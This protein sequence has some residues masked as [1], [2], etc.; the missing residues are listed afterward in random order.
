MGYLSIISSILSIP[1]LELRT[2]PLNPS[3][4]VSSQTSDSVDIPVIGTVFNP[5]LTYYTNV[6]LDTLALSLTPTSSTPAPPSAT[7]ASSAEQSSIAL[8]KRPAKN[9]PSDSKHKKKKKRSSAIF[10]PKDDRP[11]SPDWPSQLQEDNNL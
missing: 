3:T 8:G 7:P 1:S 5:I 6:D 11:S 9:P 4:P 10:A 2:R